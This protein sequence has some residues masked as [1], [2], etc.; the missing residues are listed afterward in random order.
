MKK[1]LI[2][3][4]AAVFI[5]LFSGTISNI[6]SEEWTG[7]VVAEKKFEINE[8]AKLVI[9]HEFG[10]VRCK[11]WDQNAISVKVTVRVK[12]K[13]AQKAGK[14]IDG[15]LV[16]VHG[17]RDKVVATCDLNQKKSGNTKLQVTIDFD[18]FMPA[19]ISLEMEQKFGTAYVESVSGPTEIS[20]AY[21][22]I[23]IVSLGNAE[24]NLELKFGEANI[25]NITNGEIEIKYSSI[26]LHNA[27]V[28]SVESEYSDITIDNAKSISFELEGGNTTIGQVEELDAVTN[29]ANLE[30]LN[31]TNTLMAE[32]EYGNLSIEN[33]AKDFSSIT[34]INEF[35]AVAINIDEGATYSLLAEGEYCSFSYPEKLAEISHKMESHFSTLIKGVIGKGVNPKSKLTVKSKYGAVDISSK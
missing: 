34:I 8:S 11:N 13:D 19:T 4:S 16:D 22:S 3:I 35:G 6:Y 15:V 1:S 10:N 14:I 9:D 20:S 29:F 27:D 17:N 23:E 31:I 5:F 32:T 28:L 12:T 25:K 30:V 2:K 26:E 21:G 7:K 24:N 18:I 33:V